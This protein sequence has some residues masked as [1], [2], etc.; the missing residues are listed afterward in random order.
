MWF[1]QTLLI[2][3]FVYALSPSSKISMPLPPTWALLL[4]GAALGLLSQYLR[5]QGFSAFGMPG[6]A[7]GLAFDTFFFFAGCIAKDNGWLESIAA[8]K[9]SELMLIRGISFFS[10]LVYP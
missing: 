10:I 7:G 5:E 4:V 8:I 3:N 9:G 1:V 6:G 2:F